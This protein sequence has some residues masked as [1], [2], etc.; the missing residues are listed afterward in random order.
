MSLLRVQFGCGL[1]A[2]AGWVNFDSTPT[3]WIAKLPLSRS[4]AGAALRLGL[5]PK[6]TA[7]QRFLTNLRDTRARYGDIT[8]GLP[9]QSMI[10]SQLY[11]SH[12]IE[13]LPL[14]A[15]RRALAECKRILA[16][17]GVFRMVVPDLRYF[18]DRYI[19]SS[20]A[21]SSST[22][23]IDFCLESGMG[24]RKWDS[25]LGRIRGDRH[26]LMHDEASLP[27]LLSEAGFSHIRRAYFGDSTLDFSA[28]ECPRRWEEPGTIGFEC[29][30]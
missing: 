4:A 1:S 9:L 19:N 27:A 10:V 24:T 13:H 6:G 12:V 29:S 5:A 26:H 21:T 7:R 14:D 22:A 18:I 28:V 16:R 11:A 20:Q 3:L 30:N 25:F 23:A 2:P 17:G 15:T 8:R